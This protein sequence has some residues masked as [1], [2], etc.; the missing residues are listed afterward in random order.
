MFDTNFSRRAIY[1]LG[2][3]HIKGLFYVTSTKL[4]RNTTTSVSLSSAR[5]VFKIQE[6]QEYQCTGSNDI[7]SKQWRLV[8]VSS[9]GIADP[10]F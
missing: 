6:E 4:K 3:C 5:S 7:C 2:I 1:L 8:R 10:E 9:V